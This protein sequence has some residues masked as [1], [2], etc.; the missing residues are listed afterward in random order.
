MEGGGGRLAAEVKG[1]NITLQV[2]ESWTLW[3]EREGWREEG[4][5]AT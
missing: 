4:S 1:I 3:T 2:S 5:T